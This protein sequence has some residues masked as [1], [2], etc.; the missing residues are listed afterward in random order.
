MRNYVLGHTQAVLESSYQIHRVDQDLSGPA[1]GNAKRKLELFKELGNM[2]LKRDRTPLL[3]VSPEGQAQL[4]K[5]FRDA[6]QWTSR[7]AWSTR[8]KRRWQMARFSFS[9]RWRQGSVRRSPAALATAKNE[10]AGAVSS[11]H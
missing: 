7:L 8:S 1:F 4:D 6:P 2:S 9:S 5:P 11:P 10:D 3:Y